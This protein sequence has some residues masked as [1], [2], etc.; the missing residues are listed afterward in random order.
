TRIQFRGLVGECEGAIN[1]HSE[2][3]GLIQRI[4]FDGIQLHQKL[5]PQA[6]QGLYDVRPPC[7]PQS[8]TGMGMDNA[9]CLNPHSGRAWGVEPY[10]GGLPVMYANG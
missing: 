4:L 9:W 10:P 5:N 1:L 3:A 6:E 8:P 2:P 7:N